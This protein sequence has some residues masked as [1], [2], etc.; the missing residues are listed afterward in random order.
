M[1]PIITYIRDG[2][3]S[4]DP[5]EAR[6][7]RVKSSRF[8]ILNDKLYKRGL[9]Q[10]YLKCLDSEDAAYMLNE[11]HKGVCGNHSSPRSLVGKVVRAG[12]F[13]LTMQKDAA[14]V[15]HK[16]DKCQ[17]FRNVQHV[18]AEHMTNISSP[19]LFST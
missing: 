1:N 7:I 16:C 15:V 18:P 8:T 5:S 2:T 9:S 3:L 13:W 12:H 17:R 11:I 14:Q 19:W 6:K 4:P 10:P